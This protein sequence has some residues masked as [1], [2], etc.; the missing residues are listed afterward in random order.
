[1]IERRA[2]MVSNSRADNLIKKLERG[3]TKSLGVFQS[4]E[5]EAWDE[6]IFDMEDSWS[7]R[8]LVAHFVYSEEYLFAIAKDIRS[9]GEGFPP[10][11]DIDEFNRKEMEKYQ[12]FSVGDLL[13][14]LSD[15]RQRTIDWV[16]ELEELDLDKVGNHPVLGE[17]SV[18]TVVFSIYAHQLLHMRELAS[19]LRK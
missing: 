7:L 18:E 13:E 8:D 11:V 10:G 1:V 15:V 5:N 4:I 2:G 17:S 3:V 19:K 9:G 12:S 6:P 16:R 14:M